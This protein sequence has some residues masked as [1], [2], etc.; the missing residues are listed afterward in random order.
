MKSPAI[1]LVVHGHFY[2]PPRENPWTDDLQREPSAAPAHD[3]NARIHAECYRANAFARIHD[4]AGHIRSIVNNYER[5]SFNFGPTLVRWMERVDR[6]THAR[7]VAADAEQR[8]RLGH[9]G[10]LAQAYAHP[11]VPL[12]T[13]ADRR[14]HLLWGLADFRRR[15]GREAEGLWLPE[16]AVSPQTLAS[17]IDLGVKFTILAPEQIAAVRPLGAATAATGATG[18][19]WTTVDRQTLDTGRAYRWLH[20]D[21]SGRSIDLAVFDGPLSRAVAFGDAISRAET[22]LDEVKASAQRSSVVGQRLVLCASDGELFGHHK[23]FADLALAFAGF[24]EAPRRDIEVTNVAAFLARHPPTW[25]ARLADGPDGEGTAWSCPHGLGRWR[26]DCGCNM[27]SAEL[28]WNQAWRTPLRTALDRIRD[29]AADLYEDAGSALFE[30]PWGARD[31]YGDVVDASMGE[32]DE[33]LAEFGQ[34]ALVQG[35][36]DAR[37]QARLLMEMQRATLLMYASCAWFFDDIAGLESSLVLRLGAHAVDLFTQVR[38]P[39]AGRTLTADVLA[40]LGEARSNRPEEG[41]GAD[42]YRRVVR[43][44]VTGAQAIATSALGQLVAA[45]SRRVVGGSLAR[46]PSHEA[47]NPLWAAGQGVVKPIDLTI[48]AG[49][50]VHFLESEM[51]Q[52]TL[53][54]TLTGKG[55]AR[56]QRSG[57]VEDHEFVAVILGGVRFQCQVGDQMFML[58]DLGP[59]ER[60]GLLRAALPF[61]LREG[62]DLGVMRENFEAVRA[63]GTLEDGDQTPQRRLFAGMLIDVLSRPAAALGSEALAFAVELYDAAALP[64]GAGERRLVEELVA[65]QLAAGVHAADLALLARRLGFSAEAIAA[66]RP[67][68]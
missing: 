39:A 33:L 21:G 29:A 44:R 66:D 52:A 23:K 48:S 57:V 43:Q 11:I 54:P 68:T 4:A 32:R 51:W 15:F 63:L 59:D 65:Q 6:R 45:R 31:A 30:D 24:I 3:W 56:Q 49:Y 35:R 13:P 50:N 40:I 5:L 47:W 58:A 60:E 36:D 41:T 10:A 55:R 38:G 8:R 34:P 7:L 67:A 46:A 19:K 25:E 42:V 27:G 12:L 28:G 53:G 64:V 2:Q 61:L 16:T 17:L 1:A 22:F 14:T 9:G 62:G 26:R 37:D 18:G 20:P